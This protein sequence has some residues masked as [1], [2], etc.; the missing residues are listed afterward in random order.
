MSETINCPYCGAV[1]PHDSLFCTNCGASLSPPKEVIPQP[2]TSKDPLPPPPLPPPPTTA[3]TPSVP[4]PTKRGSFHPTP[5][6]KVYGGLLSDGEPYLNYKDT[7][8][9]NLWL[10]K[11]Y[12]GLLAMWEKK[13][14]K[15]E[16][17]GNRS[18][19]GP[20]ALIIV[21]II[22]GF[23]TIRLLGGIPI[24]IGIVMIVSRNSAKNKLDR[25]YGVLSYLRNYLK[26]HGTTTNT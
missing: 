18:L 8:L 19:A 23:F 2:S 16:R 22:I 9:H 26:S 24:A 7:T 15:T 5:F 21:G 1:N 3:Y 11:N 17:D 10:T 14:V 6:G 12:S 13:I 4:S 25:Y 20:I